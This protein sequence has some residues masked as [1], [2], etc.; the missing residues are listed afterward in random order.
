MILHILYVFAGWIAWAFYNSV[1]NSD[2]IESKVRNYNNMI[3]I[4]YD[5]ITYL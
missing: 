2:P 3:T 5:I 4:S 1:V